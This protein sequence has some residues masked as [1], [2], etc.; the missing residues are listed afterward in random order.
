MVDEILNRHSGGQ[1]VTLAQL[2][3]VC[4]SFCGRLTPYFVGQGFP[5]TSGLDPFDDHLVNGMEVAIAQ[6]FL[7]QPFG[8]WFYVDRH[9][10]TLAEPVQ[11]VNSMISRHPGPR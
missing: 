9:G 8:F 2:A 3:N 11:A 6:L 7:H 1:P 5:F 10:R 4:D